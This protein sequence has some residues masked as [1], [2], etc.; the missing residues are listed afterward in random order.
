MRDYPSREAIIT[1]TPPR[2]KVSSRET[3][4][5]RQASSKLKEREE[6]GGDSYVRKETAGKI[7]RTD[8]RG[9]RHTKSQSWDEEDVSHYQKVA[10]ERSLHKSSYPKSRSFESSDGH[11]GSM[12]GPSNDVS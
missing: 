10:D 7:K 4:Y 1:L 5:R 11:V 9:D 6:I 12:P 2:R 8:S 3:R